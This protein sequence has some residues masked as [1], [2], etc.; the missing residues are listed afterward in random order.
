MSKKQGHIL[1]VDDDEDILFTSQLLLKHH[2]ETVQIESNP[3]NIPQILNSGSFDIILLDMNYLGSETSGKEGLYWLKKIKEIDESNVVIMMTAFGNT[4]T[5]VE[6]IKQGATDFVLKPWQ[7]EKLLATMSAAY[8]LRI[9]QQEVKKLKSAQLL[10]GEDLDK[11]LGE[12]IGQSAAMTAVYGIIEKVAITDANVLILGEN[13]TGKELVARALHR[14]SLRANEA[15]ISVDLG[16]LSESLFESEL[17]GHMKGAFTDAREDRPGRFEIAS[18]G[19]LFLDE[20]GNTPLSLQSKLLAT[21]QNRE[22]VRL[23]SNKAI[24]IDIRLVCATNTPIYEKV[25][26]G[27]FRQDLLYRINTVEILLPP[28]RERIEDIPLLSGYFL[29]R[30]SRKYKRS[31]MQISSSAIKKLQQY[32]WPGN[33]RELEHVIERSVI[34][35]DV[36]TLKPAD[37]FFSEK[38]IK[39]SSNS[40]TYNLL[41]VEQNVIRR[42]IDKNFGNISKAARDLGIT[43]AALYRRMEKHGIQ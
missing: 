20:I 13:G 27:T 30:Y 33:V 40:E 43:R 17:F 22:V 38:G 10:I 5:A 34:M 23:G 1:I 32:S 42:A 18:S 4:D 15:L 24:K 16:S 26:D 11:K 21:L 9:S 7:N 37:F 25:E 28:L 8:Q 36:K 2:F 14:Q 31:K 12:F 41:Q 35:C 39:Q 3:K 29:S 6:C 19:T